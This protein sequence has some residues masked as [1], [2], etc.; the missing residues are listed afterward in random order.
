MY[1][2]AHFLKSGKHVVVPKT[3]I[4]DI[5][6]HWEKFVNNSLNRNQ[7]FLCFYTESDEAYGEDGKPNGDFVPDFGLDV[8]PDFPKNGCYTVKLT[9]YKGK[10]YGTSVQMWFYF[11]FKPFSEC[12]A[13]ALNIVSR[14][15]SVAPALYNERR[16]VEIPIPNVSP[17]NQ[18]E[19]LMEAA[20]LAEDDEIPENLFEFVEHQAIN[21]SNVDDNMGLVE[22][23]TENRNESTANLLPGHEMRDNIESNDDIVENGA[24]STES[25]AENASTAGKSMELVG[26]RNESTKNVSAIDKTEQNRVASIEN[27]AKTVSNVGESMGLVENRNESPQNDDANL[28]YGNEMS[29]SNNTDG[30]ANGNVADIIQHS[31]IIPTLSPEDPLAIIPNELMNV[32]LNFS[33]QS[34]GSTDANSANVSVCDQIHGTITEQVNILTDCTLVPAE[35]SSECDPLVMVVKSEA[36]PMIEPCSSN[37]NELNG[38]FDEDNEEEDIYDDD[39]TF[40]VNKTVGFAKPFNSTT[41]N[42][43]KREN[44]IISGNMAFDETVSTVNTFQCQNEYKYNKSLNIFSLEIGTNLHVGR[45]KAECSSQCS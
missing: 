4:H 8:D 16:L 30:V 44:D 37:S 41:Q 14:R 19:S 5:D 38:L 6:V 7:R 39:I 42:L 45:E 21:T 22:Q 13:A 11:K 2:V 17:L 43:I 27:P 31:E 34:E 33:G 10:K 9:Y 23:T 1:F 35:A 29:Q 12:Y 40:I 26:D 15:R 3:W 32:S 18:N 20:Q 28:L 25:P 24:T 36:V